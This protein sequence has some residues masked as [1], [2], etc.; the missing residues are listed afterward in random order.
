MAKLMRVERRV[1]ARLTAPS[2]Y[3]LQDTGAGELPFPAQPQRRLITKR[4][5]STGPEVTIQVLDDI[6][7]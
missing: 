1:D 6:G 3:Q 2:F 4:A 7:R 5:P